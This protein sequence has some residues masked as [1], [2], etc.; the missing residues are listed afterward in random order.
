VPYEPGLPPLEGQ[1]PAAPVGFVEG[2]TTDV[3]TEMVNLI[4]TSRTYQA[5]TKT[6]QTVD[7]MLGQ[8]INLKV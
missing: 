3:A 4:V 5:N 6:V 7:D 8:V 2:S 1:N